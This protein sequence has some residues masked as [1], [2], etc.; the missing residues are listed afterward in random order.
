MRAN[1]ARSDR[2]RN[3]AGGKKS[4]EKQSW[5]VGGE[6]VGGKEIDQRDSFRQDKLMG[7]EG[8]LAAERPARLQQHSPQPGASRLENSLGKKN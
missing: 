2:K 6:S 8:R 5:Q 4:L 3:R 7:N 1:N